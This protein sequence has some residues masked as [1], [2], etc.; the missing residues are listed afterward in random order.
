MFLYWDFSLN[1]PITIIISQWYQLYNPEKSLNAPMDIYLKY[2]YILMLHYYWK[3]KD[4]WILDMQNYGSHKNHNSSLLYILN[5][6]F[7]ITLYGII[8]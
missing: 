5:V 6:V 3:Y 1:I 4:V 2:K 7:P 8:Y